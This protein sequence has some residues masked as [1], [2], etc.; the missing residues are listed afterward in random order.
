VNGKETAVTDVNTP[1]MTSQV[2]LNM[3]NSGNKFSGNMDIGGEAW[4]DV[5]W[6]GL[7]FDTTTPRH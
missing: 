4:L 3:W 2:I 7:L 6:V 1:N 5:Q